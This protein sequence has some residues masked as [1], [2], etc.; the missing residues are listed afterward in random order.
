MAYLFIIAQSNVLVVRV[1]T[2][3]AT[4]GVPGKNPEKQPDAPPAGSQDSGESWS[5][6]IPCLFTFWMESKVYIVALDSLGQAE[7]WRFGKGQICWR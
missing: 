6:C 3:A 1:N 2:E 7:S 4:G 5:V